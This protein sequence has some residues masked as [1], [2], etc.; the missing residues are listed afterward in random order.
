MKERGIINLAKKFD[1]EREQSHR[2]KIK[3]SDKLKM[4]ALKLL[5]Q[6]VKADVLSQSL[7]IHKVTLSKWRRQ[8]KSPFVKKRKA[9]E[10]R[11]ENPFNEVHVQ[12]VIQKSDDTYCL[13]TPL[14][15]KIKIEGVAHMVKLI[16]GLEGWN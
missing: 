5:S 11:A 7:K 12:Q 4:K 9:V 3:Y 6:G 8:L 1:L 10:R 15:L 2:G 14:G 16:K 13:E